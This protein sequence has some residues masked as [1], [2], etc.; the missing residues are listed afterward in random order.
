MVELLI[1]QMCASAAAFVYYSAKNERDRKRKKLLWLMSY[2]AHRNQWEFATPY[3]ANDMFNN[4]KT[5]TAATG[6]TDKIDNFLESFNRRFFPSTWGNL[7]DTFGSGSES[8][9]KYESTVKSGVY[10]GWDKWQRDLFKFTPYHNIFEQLY[11][12][13]AKDRYYVHEIMKQ[14]D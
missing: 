2:I 6:T 13:D 4:V 14:N 1:W 11:G 10:K 9:K 7:Y 8:N 3:R 12:S 5:L